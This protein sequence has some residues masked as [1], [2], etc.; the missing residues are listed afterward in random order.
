LTFVRWRRRDGNFSSS[1]AA[2]G[3]DQRSKFTQSTGVAERRTSHVRDAGPVEALKRLP[4][5]ARKVAFVH[6]TFCGQE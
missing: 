5:R 3:S 4:C 6:N 2:R 1:H